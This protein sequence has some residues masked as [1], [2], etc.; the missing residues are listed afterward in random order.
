MT[1]I[2]TRRALIPLLLVCLVATALWASPVPASPAGSPFGAVEAARATPDGT[3]LVDG[4]AADPDSG[5]AIEVLIIVDGTPQPT[6]NWAEGYRSDVARDHPELG[7]YHG[8]SVHVWGLS[9]RHTVCVRAANMGP[10]ADT[11]IGCIE[12]D[13]P[14]PRGSAWVDFS[15]PGGIRVWGYAKDP[16]VDGPIS[17][18]VGID[19]GPSVEIRADRPWP[20]SAAPFLPPRHYYTEAP[21]VDGHAFE[22]TLPAGDGNHRVRV[23][24][25]NAGPGSD[26]QFLLSAGRRGPGEPF[27]SVERLDLGPD[28]LRVS[29]W[30]VDP[31]TWAPVSVALRIGSPDATPGA[32]TVAELHRDDLPPTAAGVGR[33][34][35][36]D[37]I[38]AGAGLDGRLVC[39]EARNAA[40][41][42]SDRLLGC[43][44]VR[45]P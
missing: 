29:G 37:L 42:G 38:R 31:D 20:P 4:W 15:A 40:G 2:L 24:A 19:D 32:P 11:D 14:D 12:G 10:G 30:A 36:F 45:L 6:W 27:G 17:V 35:G 21:W 1:P 9:G 33:D 5:E 34:H 13:L 39:V 28:G 7:G 44:T 41:P 43:K 22:A 26:Q 18:S 23:V 16:D 3:L 8:F 25:L